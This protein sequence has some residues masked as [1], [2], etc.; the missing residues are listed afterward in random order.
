[1]DVLDWSE[2]IG[3]NSKHLWR[4]AHCQENITYLKGEMSKCLLEFL[5]DN[6]KGQ[7]ALRPYEAF[8]TDCMKTC[9]DGQCFAQCPLLLIEVYRGDHELLGNLDEGQW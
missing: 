8:L 4:C 7:K 3:S 2:S 9:A 6:R 1:M 5:R